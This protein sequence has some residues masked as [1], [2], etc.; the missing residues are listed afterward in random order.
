MT[1]PSDLK[2]YIKLCLSAPGAG[3]FSAYRTG[4]AVHLL[5]TLLIG[6]AVYWCVA[7]VLMPPGWLA[8]V[9][10]AATII[11]TWGVGVLIGMMSHYNGLITLIVAGAWL[12]L[13]SKG[14]GDYVV[15]VLAGAVVHGVWF[16]VLRIFGRRQASL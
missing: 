15:G 6:G 11:P 12:F 9:L 3:G 5:F 7:T 14:G 16:G 13:F 2:R 4:G 1:Q 8:F 10:V